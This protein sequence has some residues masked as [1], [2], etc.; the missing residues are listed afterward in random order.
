MK[1][2][3]LLMV[4]VLAF[5]LSSAQQIQWMSLEEAIAAQK[6]TPKK[7]FM[8]V[9]TDWCGPCKL[10]DK[11]TFQNPD[12]SMYISE[13]YYAVKFNAEGQEE[14]NFFNQTYT[15]PSYDPNRKGR[16][17]THQFTQYLGV[18]GYPTMVFFSENGAPIMPVVGYLKPQQLEL[19]LKMI[20][21]GDYQVFSKPEDFEKY[22]KSFIPRFRG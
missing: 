4:S 6:I 17:G 3:I 20:K 13:H 1:K 16:N 9:Y 21:Q 5:T 2:Q 18:K 7:I 8:D 14:I 11:K 10:L 15:N 19:Y 22:Q 12:V